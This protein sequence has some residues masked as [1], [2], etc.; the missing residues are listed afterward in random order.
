MTLRELLDQWA[1]L[2][3]ALW[4]DDGQL[5]Y[6]APRGIVTTDLIAQ[7]RIHK[8]DILEQLRAKSGPQPQP[9]DRFEPFPLTD[10][11]GAYLMGRSSV[12]DY[13]GVACHLYCEVD[14]PRL[15][16]VRVADAWRALI[17]RH[18]ML[19]VEIDASGFQRVLPDVP[20]LK[21]PV[22]TLTS[23]AP[24]DRAEQLDR[25]RDRLSHSVH[26]IGS[27]PM[28]AVELTQ[29]A[30]DE[31]EASTTM[32]I[33]F[34]FLVGDWASLLR[35]IREWEEEYAG[36]PAPIETSS[37]QF[38]DYVLWEL[39]RREGQAYRSACRYWRQRIDDLPAAPQLPIQMDS[40]DE[41]VS[42]ASAAARWHGQS[43]LLPRPQWQALEQ[44]AR[45]HGL[46]ATAAVMA[47]YADVLSR[48]AEDPHFCLNLTVLDRP[49]EVPELADVIG[50]FTSVTLLETR[51][52]TRPFDVRAREMLEQLF[53]DL[54][55]RSFSGVEVMREIARTRG[56]ETA[57]M[58]YV[59]TS[60]IGVGDDDRSDESAMRGVIRYTI[61]QTPQAF[62]DCQ[63]MDDADG[64]HVHWD[65]REGVFPAGMSADMFT[66]FINAL[67]SLA[68]DI[69]SWSA[70]PVDLP[71]RQRRERELANATRRT[72]P[73]GMLHEFVI[74]AA[75]IAPAAPAVLGRD[76][77][78]SYEEL[79]W[80]ARAVA[81]ELTGA[82]V[83]RGDRVAI[84]VPKSPD[85]IA[86]V[87]GVLIAGAAY[88]PLDVRHP[89]A[90]LMTICE[91]ARVVALLCADGHRVT[92][93]V[94]IIDMD[95]LPSANN[96]VLPDIRPDADPDD[97]AY[98]IYTSG[99]TGRPKGVE[100]SHRAVVNTIMDVN[101]RFMLD[102]GDRTLAIAD[103]GFDLSVYD[104]FG[105][106]SVGA[107][108]VLPPADTV[109]A[110]S[111]WL[112]VAT[113][114]RVTIMNTVPAVAQLLLTS[115]KNGG[116][117]P[118]TI[119]QWI[120]SGDRIPPELVRDLRAAF[121]ETRFIAMGG[122]TEAAIWSIAHP[123]APDEPLM[124]SVPY[125]RPLANQRFAVLDALGRDAP[126]GVPG[127]L[128]IMGTGLARGYSGNHELTRKSFI[129]DPAR[130]RMY[131]TGDRGFYL[132]EGEIEILG[133]LDDQVK[134]RGHRIELGEIESVLVDHEAV[135]QVAVVATGDDAQRQLHA[136]VVPAVIA[137][138]DPLPQ[139]ARESA[140]EASECVDA[141]DRDGIA[142]YAAALEKA[143]IATLTRT[144][145]RV[146]T[147]LPVLAAN[148][149]IIDVWRRALD[150]REL[151]SH[152]D[153]EL[154]GL[155]ERVSHLSPHGFD[156]RHFT[157]YVR[158]SADRLP[159]LLS[160]QASA[161]ELLLPGGNP[162][163]AEQIHQDRASIRWGNRMIT[164]LVSRAAA[165]RGMTA[166]L[167]VLEIG[168]GAGSTTE[169]VRAGLSN[170][171]FRYTFTDR[172]EHFLPAARH[173]WGG[174]DRWRFGT[175]DIDHDPVRQGFASRS[176]DLVC[177]FGVLENARDSP[178]A[179]QRLVN[180][181]ADDG[182]I[183]LS[184]PVGPQWWLYLSQIFLMTRPGDTGRQ[185]LDLFPPTRWW[186]SQL[187]GSAGGAIATLPD[188]DS[189]LAPERFA[190]FAARVRAG[191]PSA[192]REALSSFL[193]CR[194]PAVMVPQ[195]IEFVPELPLTR[196]GKIDKK[197]LAANVTSVASEDAAG[198]SGSNA[199]PADLETSSLPAEA[200]TIA[201]RI[202]GLW[203]E[204]LGLDGPL[205]HSANPFDLGANSIS[206]AS[207]A[208]RLRDETPELTNV[209]FE[210][211]LRALLG[212]ENVA[213]AAAELD[214][215]THA[216]AS[217]QSEQSTVVITPLRDRSDGQA[218]PPRLTVLF[219]DSLV[220]SVSMAQLA[221]ILPSASGN[222][223]AVTL[224]DDDWFI[225]QP[226]DVVT[227]EIATLTAESLKDIEAKEYSL[228]GYS[229][230]ALVAMET[231]RLLLEAGYRITPLGLIDPQVVPLLADD[232][233]SEVMF[234]TKFGVALDAVVPSGMEVPTLVEV[235]NWALRARSG[236]CAP[237][238]S[239]VPVLQKVGAE[240]SV[241]RFFEYLTSLDE[242]YRWQKYYEVVR[243]VRRHTSP[244][245]LR[246]EWMRY[247]HVMQAAASTPDPL[248]ADA[249]I[250]Q[251]HSSHGFL[252]DAHEW[253]ARMWQDVLI[254]TVSI[255]HT[256]GDHFTM[257]SGNH[258]A[259][260]GNAL[261]EGLMRLGVFPA[262][263][264]S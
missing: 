236:P 260:T 61:S 29:P 238:R 115:L 249:V 120:L 23:S 143:C 176:Y 198:R 206:A 78:V 32:H 63:V 84:A 152:T 97:L 183:V 71:P 205:T 13:G 40:P 85:Q 69:D 21:V 27:W 6:R 92:E 96:G 33:S 227:G 200:E 12:F 121:P 67:S 77:R 36:R 214:R 211:V 140:K 7:L 20:P 141:S 192:S 105:P 16:P 219:S 73:V 94:P 264:N 119:R 112:E 72:L 28:F 136:F 2:G 86:A 38:R 138:D 252:P 116:A 171:D 68:G 129:N 89:H 48:W 163:V 22:T 217:S 239:S 226:T 186:A 49:P 149:W 185:R 174:D 99:S 45:E 181:A 75:R 145:D 195:Q 56:R 179:L 245:Q 162:A 51:A 190:F 173:R 15:D 167:R 80:R 88:V 263:P 234:L 159:A 177:A 151:V 65:T 34:D 246:R 172:S 166:P 194:L 255:A 98:V 135:E 259:D 164:A 26:P 14:Y 46:T 169:H 118:S 76:V 262:A 44:H 233:L 212:A 79:L 50:D 253:A 241:E 17:G 81:T 215:G 126:I 103:L 235:L 156:Y 53:T 111:T 123:I 19:R 168:A 47:C 70:S 237:R 101:N 242:H 208:G 127:E 228:I 218:A 74:D 224:A 188:A 3:I 244:D 55:H 5:R 199:A 160:G 41:T 125:G 59:F 197:T 180:L 213:T 114:H 66:A 250:I 39:A 134:I 64:L 240:A 153:S 124:A 93:A 31:T 100:L 165:H 184:E 110:P 216:P 225:N 243:T 18:D 222:I 42:S 25:V 142:N 54:D 11:Q 128:V 130:G 189:A 133:R 1:D 139:W 251:P 223:V 157:S 106:L 154:H 248:I 87:L 109:I 107:A 104:L 155:W 170:T 58:P 52:D 91:D 60:A 257:L 231:A 175:L 137:G 202:A 193:S 220:D 146:E 30:A 90:R 35:L 203:A 4:E 122:A 187:L 261:I 37:I 24:E 258:V 221:A 108:V 131:R 57:V 62:L 201:A 43:F 144:L 247:R 191:S 132:P 117:C 83:R 229:Y 113:E 182:M 150:G 254:G 196:N 95:S 207:V 232:R 8:D 9:N 147:G 256:G 178:R 230:G 161:H 209:S 148:E 204:Q 210:T 102:Q 10:V 82:G 158:R